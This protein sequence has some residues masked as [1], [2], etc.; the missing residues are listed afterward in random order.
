M[1]GRPGCLD[2][3]VSARRTWWPW[4]T[5]PGTHQH[6]TFKWVIGV[7][8]PSRDM[9][10]TLHCKAYTSTLS[11]GACGRTLDAEIPLLLRASGG[12]TPSSDLFVGRS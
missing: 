7:M 1:R 8:E 5:A 4:H 12:L 3:G 9:A 6:G 11:I 10:S 2:Y